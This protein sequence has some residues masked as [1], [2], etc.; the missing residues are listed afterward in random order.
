MSEM[1]I[2]LGNALLS[3]LIGIKQTK[4]KLNIEDVGALFETMAKSLTKESTADA[5]IREEIEKIASYISH[6]LEEIA[7]IAPLAEEES[8]GKAGDDGS[9][10][11]N[12]SYA[13]AELA[14]VVAATEQAT[15]NILDA[16]DAIQNRAGNIS[17]AATK[18]EIMDATV[19]IYDACNFQDITGQRIS[20]VART[21]D[22]INTKIASLRS[23]I[24]ETTVEVH[25]VDLQLHDKRPDAALMNGPQLPGAAP[26]QEEIDRLF[27]DAR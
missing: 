14:A 2:K 13:N 27:S 26:S 22:Y 4:N 8:A 25:E 10:I 15:N 18:N 3:G 19:K 5:F 24:E 7:S 16:A 12:I 1:Q 11:R 9:S 20:K 17:D 23:V 21:L 6:A